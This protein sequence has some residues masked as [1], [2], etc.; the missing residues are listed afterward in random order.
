MGDAQP[1]WILPTKK[2]VY[3]IQFDR[4]PVAS[5]DRLVSLVMQ[6]KVLTGP[7]EEYLSSVRRALDSS[8]RFADLIPQP[9]PE[10]TIRE[11]LVVFEQRLAESIGNG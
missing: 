11:F 8:E 9:H 1:S 7:P 6:Q 2:L 4:E 10:H 3:A 5:V